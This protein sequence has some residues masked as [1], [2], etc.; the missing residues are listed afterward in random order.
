M[1]RDSVDEGILQHMID[2]Q[3]EFL[4]EVTDKTKAD[5]KAR[6]LLILF[7]L[8]ADLPYIREALLLTMKALFVFLKL[9]KYPPSTLRSS[10]QVH[11]LHEPSTNCRSYLS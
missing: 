7:S 6:H 2:S 10:N 3:A 5:I 1:G 4:M 8:N 9:L 11:S